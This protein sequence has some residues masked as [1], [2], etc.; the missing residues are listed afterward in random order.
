MPFS[1]DA[2]AP[3]HG[4]EALAG[5]V[6]AF[7]GALPAG[8][9]AV[10]VLDDLGVLRAAGVSAADVLWLVRRV[11]AAILPARACLVALAPAGVVVGGDV[12]VQAVFMADTVLATLPL[13]SGYSR[14]VAGLLR[15]LRPAAAALAAPVTWHYRIAE[16]SVVVF[17]P[18]TAPATL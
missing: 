10:V 15:V 12:A 4:L 14:D 13:P 17:A 8:A 3:R 1:L 16:H 18:G 6:G 11:H 5:L 7:L 9:P 2:A